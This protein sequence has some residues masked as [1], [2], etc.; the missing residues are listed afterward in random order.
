MP[1]TRWWQFEDSKTDLGDIKP[2]TTDLAK[3]LLVQFGLIYANDWFMVPFELPTGSLARV[4]GLAVTNNFGERF[5]IGPAGRGADDWQRWGMFRLHGITAG[6]SR[7]NLLFLAPAAPKV[8]EGLPLE[9]VRL[10]RD[11]MANMVWG[12]ES[13]V[14]LATGF[15]RSGHEAAG[16]VLSYHKSFVEAQA[17]ADYKA[18]VYYLAMTTI[19]E[20]WIPLVPVHKPGDNREVQLQRS[21]MLRL[22]QGDPLDPPAKIRPRTSLLREGLDPRAGLDPHDDEAL[23]VRQPYYLH[24]EE[25]PRAGAWVRQ[26]YQRTRWTDGE[27]F[28]WLGVRKKTGKGEGSSNLAFDQVI[29]AV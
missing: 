29:D 6:D 7:D 11:E 13:I 3:L 28:V 26:H 2:S 16:E 4:K 21:A 22:I 9:E 1:E 15:G 27:V 24:E 17:V 14:P 23:Q 12:V 19:P 5:W 10:I 20:N 18:S 25:V 8:Q